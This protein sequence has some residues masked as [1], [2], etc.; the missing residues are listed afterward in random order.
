MLM[1]MRL[2]FSVKSK[3]E[4]VLLGIRRKPTSIICFPFHFHIHNETILDFVIHIP[5]IH[6]SD[7]GA[8][9]KQ[10]HEAAVYLL[11]AAS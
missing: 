6:N 4:L 7:T 2:M 8:H 9:N 11:V 1:L 10:R 3:L 5:V